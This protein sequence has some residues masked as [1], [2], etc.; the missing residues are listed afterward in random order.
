MGKLVLASGLPTQYQTALALRAKKQ[1]ALWEAEQTLF[2]CTHA[3]VGAYL[4]G[5]WGLPVPIVEAV[6]F[7]HVPAQGQNQ[8]FD[9]VIAVH[10]ANGL[11]HEKENVSS[12]QA[13]SALDLDL[14]VCLGLQ[15][16]L[17]FWKEKASV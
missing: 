3:E 17:P 16:R 13:S 9:L 8:G 2:G 6:A 12:A 11:L 15:D 4:L 7:H 10:V 1:S 14:L 5:L